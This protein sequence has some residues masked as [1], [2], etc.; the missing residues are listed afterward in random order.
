MMR[1]RT[2]ISLRQY[3][4]LPTRMV[5]YISICLLYGRNAPLFSVSFCFLNVLSNYT[6]KLARKVKEKGGDGDKTTTASA[7]G[8]PFDIN[9]NGKADEDEDGEDE[10]E[11]EDDDS[12][13]DL[14]KSHTF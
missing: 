3:R 14:V 10:D 6:G 12:D 2:K 13:V 1:T 4:Y 11:D 7:K 9:I 8:K 5:V